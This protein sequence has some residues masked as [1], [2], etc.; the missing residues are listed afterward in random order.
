MTDELLQ[1][2]LSPHM[3]AE[4]LFRE[5]ARFYI[6]TTQCFESR[7]FVGAKGAFVYTDRSERLVDFGSRLGS[8]NIGHRDEELERLAREFIKRHGYKDAVPHHDAPNEYAVAFARDLVSCM[9]KEHEWQCFFPLSGTGG[10]EAALKL[11][12]YAAFRAGPVRRK[13][14]VVAFDGAFH[15]RTLGALSLNNYTL[16]RDG[17]D[18]AYRK[19]TIWLPYPAC[20]PYFSRSSR[21]RLDYS[22]VSPEDYWVEGLASVDPEEVFALVIEDGVQGEGGMN[23]RNPEILARVFDYCRANNIFI[24]FD[25]VQSGMGR[26]GTIFAFLR[27]GFIPDAFV[28]AKSLCDGLPHGVVICRKELAPRERGKQSNTN[29][30]N[31]LLCMLGRAQLKIFEE[32]RVLESVEK[33]SKNILQ[34]TLADIANSFDA[35]H[36]VRSLGFMGGIEFWD[37][38]TKKA[39]PKLRDKV[40]QCGFGRGLLLYGC[41]LSG[42]RIMPTL[43]ISHE[44]LSW[45]LSRLKEAIRDALDMQA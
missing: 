14:K 12:S 15:G 31:P 9:P 7:R 22:R 28:L 6:P 30:G 40:L 23:V 36:S 39:D 45:S 18:V 1:E 32:R 25:G 43:T 13:K 20:H 29:G 35:V 5:N 42:V 33:A 3:S 41:G 16:H 10:V 19:R 21:K 44:L 2:L 11:C 8:A 38:K 26:T 17:F 34:P 4:E 27:D 24:I 37:P